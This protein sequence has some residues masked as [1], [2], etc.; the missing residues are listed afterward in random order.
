MTAR[1]VGS[2][3]YLPE[4]RLGN[5]DFF[6]IESIK[7]NF[8][9]ERARASLQGVEGVEKMS[10]AEVFDQWSVQ[11]T[12]IRERRILS[13]ESGLTTE[14]MCAEASR[15]ALEMAGMKSSDLDLIFVGSLTGSDVVPNPAC[16]IASMLG[17]PTLGGYTLNAACAGFV[18]GLAT[19]YAA[20]RSGLARNILVV[21]G[22]ALSRIT[23]YGDAKTSV[24]FGDGA[25][26]AVLVPSTRGDGILGPPHLGGNYSRDPL[27]L[28]GQGWET[29][30]EPSAKLHMEG[31]PSIL[32]RAIANMAEIA[33]RALKAAGR[34][35]GEVDLVIPHQANLRITMGLEKQLR[36]KKGRVLH[37]IEK[38][39]NMSASTVGVALDEALRGRHGQLPDPALIVLTAIGGGY[40]SAA[41]VIEWRGK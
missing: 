6:E 15:K 9:V 17:A 27:Y 23:N 40:S 16:T 22:D 29:E 18:Y 20:I 21:S 12:G 10:P 14:S 11:V 26:A 37:T 38:Y 2:G 3:S 1:I 34:E 36:L 28:V 24:L 30:E 39:G 5:F 35:W 4:T 8:D 31:G 7:R 19:A 25:G 33:D 13:K 32:R 41:A